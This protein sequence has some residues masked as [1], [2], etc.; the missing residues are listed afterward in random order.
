MLVHDLK[1]ALVTAYNKSQ[2]P[3]VAMQVSDV[4]FVDV[5]LELA[6]DTNSIVTLRAKPTS[7]N[8]KGECKIRYNRERLDRR[9]NHVQVPGKAIDYSSNHAVI[10][11]LREVYSL[12]IDIDDV[13]FASVVD[14]PTIQL[15]PKVESLGYLFSYPAILSFE[16]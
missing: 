8:F 11:R 9:C 6:G 2:R 12:P 16:G 13:G 3:A 14:L 4:D 5:K 10:M 7:L 15:N 1:V